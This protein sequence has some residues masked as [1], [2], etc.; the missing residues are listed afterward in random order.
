MLVT[1]TAIKAV[2]NIIDDLRNDPATQGLDWLWFH[3]GSNEQVQNELT[4]LEQL[5]SRWHQESYNEQS[6]QDFLT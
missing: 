5:I 3:S 1:S 4:R 2:E 6:Q